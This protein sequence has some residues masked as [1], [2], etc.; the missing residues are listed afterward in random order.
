MS[1][2]VIT[3]FPDFLTSE[4][5]PRLSS[6]KNPNPEP[7]ANE[8]DTVFQNAVAKALEQRFLGQPW[9]NRVDDEGNPVGLWHWSW[10]ENLAPTTGFNAGLK[11]Q[12]WAWLAVQPDG[13]I[14]QVRVSQGKSIADWPGLRK[15]ACAKS[16]PKELAE[17][18]AQW[19]RVWAVGH[20]TKVSWQIPQ[21]LPLPGT[22]TSV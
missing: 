11:Q 17:H 3:D 14:K 13:G 16:N 20:E 18:Q 15:M 12:A 1:D 4:V 2:N 8:H 7:L 21:K 10:I 9:L 22:I 19:R 6:G 5:L